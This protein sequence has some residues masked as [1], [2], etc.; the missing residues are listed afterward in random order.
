MSALACGRIWDVLRAVCCQ[1]S[2]VP[3]SLAPLL[4]RSSSL[5]LAAVSSPPCP[6][7]LCCSTGRLEELKQR[8]LDAG[9][10]TQEKM[11]WDKLLDGL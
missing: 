10:P 7:A 8:W 3:A 11:D 1:P 9:S 5:L 6:H 2:S 4:A